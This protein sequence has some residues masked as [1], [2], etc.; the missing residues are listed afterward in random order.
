VSFTAAAKAVNGASVSLDN[1]LSLE[2]CFSL[3][4]PADSLRAKFFIKQ[5]VPELYSVTLTGENISFE[6]FIDKQTEEKSEKG[7]ILTLEAR[8]RGALL[9]DNEALPQLYSNAAISDIFDRT[10]RPYGY[11]RLIMPQN[12]VLP[13]YIVRK[14]T[15]EWEAFYGFCLRSC[16]LKP[17][18]CGNEVVLKKPSPVRHQAIGKA[19]GYTSITAVYNRCAVVS[20]VCIRDS[21]GYYS[22]A[23][24]N[25]ECDELKIRR[26]RYLIPPTEFV[27][28]PQFDANQLIKKSMLDYKHIEV[29]LPYIKP[30][31]I[32][33]L[34]SVEELS[35]D[36]FTICELAYRVDESGFRTELLLNDGKYL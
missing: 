12:A 20:K 26:K 9:I 14:G 1:M 18:I 15:S 17:Y 25:N 30:F 11:E 16:G 31:N 34:I 4:T 29:V 28:S 10:I 8:S 19:A 21:G 2:I 7:I 36:F 27:K 35:A 24:N 22:S 23:V 5:S 3:N 32:G 13:A 6:G 33:D